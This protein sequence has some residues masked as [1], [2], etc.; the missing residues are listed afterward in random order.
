MCCSSCSWRKCCVCQCSVSIQCCCEPKIPRLRVIPATGDSET[1]V[2]NQL[3]P[4]PPPAYLDI[5]PG[6]VEDTQEAEETFSEVI[7]KMKVFLPVHLLKSLIA[8]LRS[9]LISRNLSFIMFMYVLEECR[10]KHQN[11]SIPE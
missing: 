3:S 8:C 7:I 6:D 5:Y 4:T 10:V 11:I 2:R 1:A 9:Y